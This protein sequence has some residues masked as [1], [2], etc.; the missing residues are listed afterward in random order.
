M[1]IEQLIFI[2]ATLNSYLCIV[3][4]LYNIQLI[5]LTIAQVPCQCC[6]TSFG[7]MVCIVIAKSKIFLFIFICVYP[8]LS[9]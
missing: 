7:S 4:K 5:P 2:V 3:P 1:V 6:L 8:N 9:S